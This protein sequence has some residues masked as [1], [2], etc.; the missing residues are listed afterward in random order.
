MTLDNFDDG[1]H[2]GKL[3]IYAMIRVEQFANW[4]YN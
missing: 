4:Y 3:T 2:V 1:V